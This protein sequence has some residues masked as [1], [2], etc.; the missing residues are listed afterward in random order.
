MGKVIISLEDHTITT[1]PLIALESI[2]EGS[3]WTQMV[4]SLRLMAE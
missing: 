1:Q 2:A 3:I 4:D